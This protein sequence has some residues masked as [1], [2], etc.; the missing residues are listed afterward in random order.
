MFV[1]LEE[2]HTEC[3]ICVTKFSSDRDSDDQEI[4]QHLPVLSSS[5]RCDHF[6]CHGC[7]LREQLRVAE[8]NH[9]TVPKWI[10]CMICR[11][12]TSFN[13]AEPKY[14]RLLIDLLAQGNREAKSGSTERRCLHK[15]ASPVLPLII[16]TEFQYNPRKSDYES[17]EEYRLDR[18]KLH[19]A[20]M[21]QNHFR[22]VALRDEREKRLR[23]RKDARKHVR[24][25][26]QE[27]EALL[28]RQQP[29]LVSTM[30]KLRQHQDFFPV[31]R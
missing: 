10:R 2:Q 21:E 3:S 5:K 18:E 7:V 15:N 26:Q 12:K 8:K 27:L 1:E 16:M 11:E 20:C 29:E 13:P 6:F 19:Y 25:K 28:K 31:S 9:G 17:E 4:R 24:K 23:Q 22:F 14:H 30:N